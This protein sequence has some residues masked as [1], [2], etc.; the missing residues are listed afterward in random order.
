MAALG[1]VSPILSLWVPFV[2]FAALIIWMY[3]RVAYVPGGQAIAW[4]EKGAA[5]VS[6]RFMVLFRL[7]RFTGN[8]ELAAKARAAEAEARAADARNAEQPHAS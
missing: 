8:R 1:L 7:L 5:W 6:K 4:L 3:W 2:L